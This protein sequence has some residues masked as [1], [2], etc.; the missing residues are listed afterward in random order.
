MPIE[1]RRITEDDLVSAARTQ[2]W[3][4][5]DQF[6]ESNLPRAR[7]WFELGDYIGAFDGPD[8]V[9]VT[10]RLPLE[11]TVPGGVVTTACI[12]GVTVLPS[13]RRRGLLTE[14][15]KRQLTAAH[16]DGT[17][18]SALEA[19]EA[20]IYGRYGY[21]I[22]AMH[23]N[24]EIDRRRTG[25]RQEYKWNGS[26]HMVTTDRA[27]E[28]FPEVYWRS[29]GSRAGVV[30][31]PKPWWPNMIDDKQPNYYVE[32]REGDVEG[33]AI[34]QIKE[35]VVMVSMLIARTEAAYA[36]LW[37]F[38]FSIDLVKTVKA[39]ARPTDDPLMWMLHDAR[40]LERKTYDRT[41]LRLVDVPKA[42]SSRTYAQEDEIVFEVRDEFCPWNDGVYELNGGP[43]G[44][45]CTPTTK[46]PDITLAADDL[47]VPYL[48]G[49]PFTPLAHAGRV[50]EH[51]PGALHRADAMFATPLKPWS[52]M[53]T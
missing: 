9:G 20:P 29:A 7:E 23:D 39:W 37:N 2:A 15:M 4:F 52:P 34:Y 28:V 36:A 42:L 12:G 30:Q 48:G 53:L 14:M 38:C 11:M 26:I 31:P 49:F 22:A 5:H 18:L 6:D 25:Y 3:A 1:Y 46:S 45:V 50:V 10:E 40:A 44:A 47:A 13:H 33:M 41:W 19:S 24:W 27:R 43:S 51:T 32:Y 17:I 35:Q 16:E 21:G 8:A